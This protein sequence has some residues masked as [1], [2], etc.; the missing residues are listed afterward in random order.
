MIGKGHLLIH[1]VPAV[2]RLK[3]VEHVRNERN[4]LA[5][6]AG[7][8]FIT[9]MITTFSDKDCLYMLVCIACLGE[10]LMPLLI[11]RGIARLL[12]RRRG[13]HIPQTSTTF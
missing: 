10:S 4:T 13:F 6:I 1:H 7:H 5:A 2:I 11:D 3:Q 12:S 8:P 9:T